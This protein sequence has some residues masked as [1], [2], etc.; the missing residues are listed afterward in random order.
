MQ[1]KNY[2]YILALLM[3][4]SSCAGL[5]R[6]TRFAKC[7]FRSGKVDNLRLADVN[8]NGIE[9]FESINLVDAGKI[10]LA[11]TRKRLPLSFTYNLEVR[12][13]NDK[14]AALST[15]DWVLVLDGTDVT[16]GTTNQRI[17]IPPGEIRNMRLDFSI[18]LF[19]VLNKETGQSLL[20]L[21]LSLVNKNKEPVKVSLKIKP[22][23]LIAGIEVKYPGY[24]KVEKEF[25]AQ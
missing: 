19:E 20:N 11:L 13:P 2:L 5:A 14:V 1:F 16:E 7:E 10:T 23:F 25:G 12:N 18:D 9:T 15:V 4:L 3:M 21:A 17:E 22:A 8:I 24:F 6:A